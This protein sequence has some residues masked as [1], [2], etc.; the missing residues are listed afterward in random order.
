MNNAALISG[1]SDRALL[2]VHGRDFKPAAEELLDICIGSVKAG[3]KRDYPDCIEKYHAVEKQIAYY[4]DISNE[5]LTSQGRRYD[6]ELDVGDRRNLLHALAAIDKRKNFGVHRYDRVPGKTAIAEF[7]AGVVGPVLG[8]LGLSKA[9]IAKVSVDLGEY[10][11][12]QNDFGDKLRDRVRDSIVRALKSDKHVMLITHGTGCVIAYDILWELSHAEEYATE[13]SGHKIDAWLTLGAPLGDS[14][15]RSRL[16]G[17]KNKG[18]EK[19]P[20]N[21]VSWYNVSAEDDYLCHDNTLA[22]DYKEMLSRKMV[23]FIKDYRIYNLSVRYGKSN[24]HSSIGYL[25]H[26]R[27][28]QIVATWLDQNPA[29]SIPMSTF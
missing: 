4:G 14:M 21:I 3:I 28:A 13:F 9:L 26:P 10:W 29:E 1:S 11:N 6:V 24:P 18:L 12:E 2:F 19:Y 22:D 25:I 5:F 17:A 15:I 27:V 23:S 20:N 16:L 8:K 7:A